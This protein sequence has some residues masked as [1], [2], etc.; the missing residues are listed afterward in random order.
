LHLV[1]EAHGQIAVLIGDGRL[2]AHD[3]A[4]GLALGRADL[5]DFRGARSGCRRG[6][7]GRTHHR[8]STF[9]PSSGV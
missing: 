9:M 3:A 2:G 6:R 4:I 8:A 5:D 7:T 1:L